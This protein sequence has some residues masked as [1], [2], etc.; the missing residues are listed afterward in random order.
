MTGKKKEVP[1]KGPDAEE[2]LRAY[3]ISLG[4][5]VVRGL[6]VSYGGFD[7]T[8]VDLWLYCKPSPISRERT[9]VDIKRKKTP[10][11]L[12]RIFWAKGLQ[13]VLGLER[14][15]VATTDSRSEL[16]DFGLKHD[17]TV[18]DG[19]FLS[20]ILAK[21]SVAGQ[22]LTEE[23]LVAA[24]DLFGGGKLSGDYAARYKSAK[25]RLLENLDFDGAN[26]WL[27]DI[28]FFL[29]Q[30]ITRP[31]SREISLRFLY[32]VVSHFLICVDYLSHSFSYLEQERRRELL[33]RGFRYGSSGLK[34]SEQ[35]VDTA[36]QLLQAMLPNA[37]LNVQTLRSEVGKQF[38]DI[39]SEIL[40]DYFSSPKNQHGVFELARTFEANAYSHVP[41]PPSALPLA[42]QALIGLLCDFLKLDRKSVLGM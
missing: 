25:S 18:L 22:R 41:L 15:I 33:I 16:R 37:A 12:E 14:V 34:R 3:F 20:K 36:S 10:Q 9:N 24:A 23:S 26:S 19:S 35:L 1:S 28:K 29:E 6:P 2:F 7:V 8:D 39:Q 38:S 27:S 17:V 13:S 4:F 42:M 11:A 32:T 21:D 30:A 31:P 40:A 5:Y